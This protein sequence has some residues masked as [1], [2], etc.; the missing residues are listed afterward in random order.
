MKKCP[1]CAEKIQDE[2]IICRYCNSNLNIPL[3]INDGLLC[4][5]CGKK[6]EHLAMYCQHCGSR[7]QKECPNC[8]EFIK[9]KARICRFC[10][11]KYSADKLENDYQ[12]EQERFDNH[13]IN[14][15]V[16]EEFDL[17]SSLKF[18]NPECPKCKALNNGEDK[19]CR[20]CS[21]SL[22]SAKYLNNPFH[23][24]EP[25]TELFSEIET[26]IRERD[27]LLNTISN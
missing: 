26:M 6:T 12:K 13:K 16:R 14:E 20:I 4:T 23:N 5:F 1:Y 24:L 7:L 11:Y 27:R 3:S 18:N 25:S 22:A 15:R 10:G 19:S 2:A 8:S 17:L 21:E 9:F